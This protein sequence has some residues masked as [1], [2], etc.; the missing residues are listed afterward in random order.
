MTHYSI[1]IDGPSGAGKSTLARA[2]ADRLGFFYVDTGAIYRTLGLY[3]ARQG[4]DCGQ[5]ADV[6]SR[7]PEV[8]ISMAYGEDGLQHMILQGEDVTGAIRENAVSRYAS[9]VSAYPEVRT[10]LLEMQRDLARTHNVIM[11]GRD[12]GTVVLPQADLKIFLTA[13]V[14]ERARRRCA[15][16]AARGQRVDLATVQAEIAQRDYDDTH[17]AAAPLRKAADAVEVDTSRM[18]WEESSGGSAYPGEREVIPLTLYQLAYVISKF[19]F[20]IVTF[21]TPLKAYGQGNI[22]KG[23]AVICSNHAHNSDP[24]YIVYSFQRQDKIWI[25]AKEEIR[26]Y[27]VVGKLLDWLGFVIWVKRGKSDVGAVKSAL[28]ALKGQ[29]KLL[30]FPEG[31]R[32]AEIGEGKTGAAMMAIRTGVPILPVYIDPERKAFRR[33]RVYIGEPYLPFP[34]KRRANAEDYEVV[35]EEI[36][37]RIRAVRDRRAEMEAAE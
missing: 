8:Q 4:G 35:T 32:H 37:N 21:R 14:E 12:I 15:E 31:T 11:D 34:E 33:T 36:M 9:Q 30:I 18:D 28:K 29:E 26:H 5:K 20:S 23:G 6:V 24:F 1:A 13:S 3:I 2:L 17:R 22:P 10:F 19:I 27:P 16:L 7:L 25:M